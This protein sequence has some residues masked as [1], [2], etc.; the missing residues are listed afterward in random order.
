MPPKDN[1][2]VHVIDMDKV[3]KI[4]TLRRSQ[5]FK[6][7]VP[8]VLEVTENSLIGEMIEKLY[9]MDS[10]L[11]VADYSDARSVFVFN[12]EGKFSHKI[13]RLGGGPG[14]YRD[15]SDFCVDTVGKII[16]ILDRAV[17]KIHKYELYSGKHIKSIKLP[18]NLSGGYSTSAYIHYNNNALYVSISCSEFTND[19]ENFLL[20]KI[21]SDSGEPIKSW[22]DFRE[23]NKGKSNNIRSPFQHTNQGDIKYNTMF[24]NM[25]MSVSENEVTPFL[26]FVG[27]DMIT[28]NDLKGIDMEADDGERRVW[29]L[30]KIYNFFNYFEGPDFIHIYFSKGL[31]YTNLLYYPKT[32]QSKCFIRYVDD[33]LY[34]PSYRPSTIYNMFLSADKKGIYTSINLFGLDDFLNNRTNGELSPVMM[35]NPEIQQYNE[36]SNPLVLYYEFKD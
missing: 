31:T 19:K 22:F 24:M 23:Y 29:A 2:G 30:N 21:D 20:H 9:A 6:S 16:Y 8:I 15:V 17:D 26:T 10:I 13:G 3:E 36:D 7:V 25:I 18:K 4:D 5:L 32:K 34:V 11:I 28:E 1:F 12:R 33:L 27:N 14:E 35:N